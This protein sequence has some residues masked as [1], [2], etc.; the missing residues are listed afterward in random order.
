MPLTNLPD[1][2]AKRQLFVALGII[3][4]KNGD[5]LLAKRNDPK[6]HTVHGYWEFPGGKI[7]FG[8]LPPATVVREVKEE[9]GLRV[10]VKNFFSAYSWVNPTRPNIQIVLLVYVVQPVGSEI[11]KPHNREVSEVAWMSLEKATTLP[12]VGNN[13]KILRD[14]KKTL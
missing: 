8:E 4:R 12:L 5:I 7:E 3:L 11:A 13:K 6:N 2:K 14:L 9:V 1:K 10:E